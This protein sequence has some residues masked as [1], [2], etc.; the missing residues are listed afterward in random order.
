MEPA[1]PSAR[2]IVRRQS[3]NG[4]ERRD[5]VSWGLRMDRE[6]RRASR[7]STVRVHDLWID[8]LTKGFAGE[9][10]VLP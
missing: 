5:G 1:R 2:P 6:A 3:V 10:L 8:T 4:T 9:G 7:E